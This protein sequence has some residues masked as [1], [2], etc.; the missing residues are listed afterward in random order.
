MQQS[1]LQLHSATLQY[2]VARA[3]VSL[4]FTLRSQSELARQV[5]AASL[6]PSAA[7]IAMCVQVRAMRASIAR[8]RLVRLHPG[9]PKE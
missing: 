7:V 3:P 5:L 8:W 9:Y 4:S 1:G 6:S 2:G